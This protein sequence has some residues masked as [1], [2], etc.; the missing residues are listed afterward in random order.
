[1]QVG[2]TSRLKT[3]LEKLWSNSDK[4]LDSLVF[5]VKEI[6]KGFK[7]ACRVA[8]LDDLRF[9]DLRRCHATRLDELGFSIAAIGN[10]LGHSGD[11]KVTLRYISRDEQSIRRVADVL[12]DNL[13]LPHTQTAIDKNSDFVN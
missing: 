12:D 5:G 3:E 13:R 4:D 1:R 11:Y 2:I 10:Q 8:N 7:S 9:H 6:R